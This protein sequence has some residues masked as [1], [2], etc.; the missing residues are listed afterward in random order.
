MGLGFKK[1]EVEEAPRRWCPGSRGM[2]WEERRCKKT[3]R[4]QGSDVARQRPSPSSWRRELTAGR[5]SCARLSSLSGPLT[6]AEL[7]L[8][9]AVAVA[10]LLVPL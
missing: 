6:A 5:S 1:E 7:P 2:A 3:K 8:A 9:R 10:T 4:K